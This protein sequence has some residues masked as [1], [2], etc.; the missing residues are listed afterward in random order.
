[1]L[2]Q[3]DGWH[4]GRTT[5]TEHQGVLLPVLVWIVMVLSPTTYRVQVNFYHYIQANNNVTLSFSS[6]TFGSFFLFKKQCHQM[7]IKQLLK[8]LRPKKQVVLLVI[9]ILI[10]LPPPPKK[11]KKNWRGLLKE[12]VWKGINGQN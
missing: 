12:P 9:S 6:F 10:T 4:Q 3:H 5:A 2:P 7:I 8:R 11:K 1:M